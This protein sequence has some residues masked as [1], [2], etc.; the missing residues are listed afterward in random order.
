[1]NAQFPVHLVFRGEIRI[2]FKRIASEY[3]NALCAVYYYN[4]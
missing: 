3:K 1:M 2:I 4:T